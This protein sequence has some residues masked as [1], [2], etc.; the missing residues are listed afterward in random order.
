MKASKNICV[1]DCDKSSE[2]SDGR[3]ESDLDE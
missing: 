2:S 3:E 1:V